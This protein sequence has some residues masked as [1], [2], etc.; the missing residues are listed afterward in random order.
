MASKLSFDGKEIEI[1]SLN[2]TAKNFLDLI[3]FTDQK[4]DEFKN[5]QALL[6]RAKR[7]YLNSLKKEMVS[8]KAGIIIEKD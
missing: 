6:V 4:L 1:E 7:S 8:K 2:D 3:Q 5:M